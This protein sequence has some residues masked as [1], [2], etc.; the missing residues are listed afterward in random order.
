MVERTCTLILLGAHFMTPSLPPTDVSDA[1][2]GI[3]DGICA[4]AS[5]ELCKL[6]QATTCGGCVVTLQGFGMT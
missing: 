4:W 1:V 3:Y 5:V 6:R 2:Q